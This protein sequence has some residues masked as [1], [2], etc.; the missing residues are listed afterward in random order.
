MEFDLKVIDRKITFRNETTLT[1][2]VQEKKRAGMKDKTKVTCHGKVEGL[3]KS[4][5][6]AKVAST[7][8]LKISPFSVRP[9]DLS[10]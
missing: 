9:I 3:V 10:A 6:D 1:N 8:A 5:N 7:T 2:H 4:Y